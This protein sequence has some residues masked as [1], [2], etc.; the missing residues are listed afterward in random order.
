VA[1]RAGNPEKGWDTI[2]TCPSAVGAALYCY[3]GR[4]PLKHM[5]HSYTNCYVHAVYSTKDRQNL[6]PKDFE[7]RLYSFL[8]SVARNHEI[9]L[10]S[11]GGMPNH[12]HLLFLLPATMS[13]ASVINTFK[14]N[15]S[16]FARAERQLPVAERI[17]RLQRKFFAT[18]QGHRVHPGSARAPQEDD[19]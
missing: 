7:N 1:S 5:S 3:P 4:E 6:I 17:W 14:S 9:P 12:S 19:F 11:A 8:A 13:L 18:R 2:R 16:R 10:L 15:S